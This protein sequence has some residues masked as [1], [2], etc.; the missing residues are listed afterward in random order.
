[1]GTVNA[2]QPLVPRGTM[3]QSDA[4]PLCQSSRRTT[5]YHRAGRK[6][7]AAKEAALPR[8]EDL[9]NLDGLLYGEAGEVH[10]LDLSRVGH[11][12]EPV[13]GKMG[14]HVDHIATR[15]DLGIESTGD[16]HH[17]RGVLEANAL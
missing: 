11:A 7:F 10:D 14:G 3:G 9:S 1:M 17:D 8:I 12:E 13:G 4:V 16:L 2:G 5:C 6:A 15:V